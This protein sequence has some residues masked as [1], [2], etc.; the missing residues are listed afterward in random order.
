M[1]ESVMNMPVAFVDWM[2]WGTFVAN[3]LAVIVSAAAKALLLHYY[4]ESEHPWANNILWAVT[5]GFAGNLSTVS[6]FVAEMCS[7]KKNSQMHIYAFGSLG[8][9]MAVGL[10]VYSPIARMS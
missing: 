9:A 1:S 7:M 6:T 4:D 2:P 3:I 10:C 5:T 8:V